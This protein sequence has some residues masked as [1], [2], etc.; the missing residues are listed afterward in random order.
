[1]KASYPTDQRFLVHSCCIIIIII[2]IIIITTT[3][4]I[5]IIIIMNNVAFRWVSNYPRPQLV[6]LHS[7]TL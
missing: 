1:M 7:P 4:I 2:I 6:C 5:I 3:T